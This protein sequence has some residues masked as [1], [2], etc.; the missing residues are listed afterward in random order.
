MAVDITQLRGV[1]DFAPMFRWNLIFISFPAIGAAGFPLSN[2]LNIRC[3]SATIPKMSNEKIEVNI[4]QHKVFQNGKGTYTNSFDL[5]FVETTNNVIH[6]FLKVWRELHHGT[7]S[8]TSV[9]KA[10]LEALIQIQRLNNEDKPVWFYTMHG[11][12]LEDYDLGNV[13]TDSDVMRP[14]ATLSYDFFEDGPL[15]VSG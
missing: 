14:S 10:D 6:N 7:R 2:D 12:L 5:T 8:G 13:G 11:C 4:R 1:G 15:T 3:E 9:P